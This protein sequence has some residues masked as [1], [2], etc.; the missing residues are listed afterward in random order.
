MIQQVLL[1]LFIF[2]SS[3][4]IHEL[5]HIKA[6][7]PLKQGMIKV[8]DFGMAAYPSGYYENDLWFRF[9]GGFISGAILLLALALS[10]PSPFSFGLVTCATM[11]IIY[12][13]YEAFSKENKI[14]VRYLIY[15]GVTFIWIMLWFVIGVTI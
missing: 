3:F 10:T 5:A 6:F 7:G 12:A 4:L 11:Q 1:F 13:V 15:L 9:S 2:L 14:E 8:Y